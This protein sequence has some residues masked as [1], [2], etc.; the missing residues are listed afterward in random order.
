MPRL[1]L[2]RVGIMVVDDSAIARERIRE[3]V[4]RHGQAEVIAEA[5]TAHDFELAMDRHRPTVVTLDLLMPGRAGLGLI[6][7]VSQRTAVVIVSESE[8]H[9]A[10][11]RESLAQGA[12]AFIPKSALGTPEGEAQL[13][14]AI[15]RGAQRHTAAQS[16]VAIAGS[17]G[18]MVSLEAFAADLATVRSGIVIVQHLPDAHMNGF[19]EWLT[20][21]GLPSEVVRG[22]TPVRTGCALIAPG[23]RHL[24]IR[25]GLAVTDD[26]P[27]VLGH[28]PSASVL[29]RSMLPYARST[30]AVVLSGMGADGADALKDLALAGARCVVQDPAT[31]G[32]DSMPKAALAA[33]P[34]GR[35]LPPSEIARGVRW[36]LTGGGP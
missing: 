21:L 24:V 28:K 1:P 12:V 9:S 3:I 23:H 5:G 6:R 8:S 26:S 32:V 33:A 19:A 2:N 30:V 4:E 18:A 17:T 13:V 34:R 22:P 27:P 16:I 31:C 11:A 35:A 36:A 7:K 25:H 14:A 20:G 15:M 10:L 29:F